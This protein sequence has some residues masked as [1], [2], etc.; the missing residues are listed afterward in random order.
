LIKVNDA[1]HDVPVAVID[2]IN[3]FVFSYQG[4]KV[5]ACVDAPSGTRLEVAVR[6]Q[7]HPELGYISALPPRDVSTGQV[8]LCVTNPMP[9]LS[10]SLRVRFTLTAPD[11]TITEQYSPD[12][13]TAL[14]G[15]GMCVESDT[16]CCDFERAAQAEDIQDAGGGAVEAKS[17]HGGCNIARVHAAHAQAIAALLLACIAALCRRHRFARALAVSLVLLVACSDRTPSARPQP[18]KPGTPARAEALAPTHPHAMS[19]QPEMAALGAARYYREQGKPEQA[20]AQLD[21][22]AKRY[23]DPVLPAERAAE[24]AATL[25]ALGRMDEA[26]RFL[27]DLTRLGAPPELIA[28]ANAACAPP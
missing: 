7:E 18:P 24:R 9:E 28:R 26:K 4:R 5:S 12:H 15:Q 10:G 21:V 23:P 19:L 13:V 3:D 8:A 11:G 20:L 25:C 22:L 16:V 2:P 14:S 17:E 27:A 1:Q 6:F